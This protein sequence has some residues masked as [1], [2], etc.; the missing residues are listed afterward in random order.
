MMGT[1]SHYLWT[2]LMIWNLRGENK[3]QQARDVFFLI[4]FLFFFPL[5]L[6]ALV[7]FDAKKKYNSEP[8]SGNIDKIKNADKQF[9]TVKMSSSPLFS[10]SLVSATKTPPFYFPGGTV[11]C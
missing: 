3:Q 8:K 11:G 6:L 4:F 5:H 10:S 2:A 9:P 7:L 1:F